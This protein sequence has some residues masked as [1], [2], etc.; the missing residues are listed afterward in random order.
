M[1]DLPNNFYNLDIYGKSSK[2]PYNS[3]GKMFGYHTLGFGSGVAAGLLPTQRAILGFGAVASGGAA[4][5]IT[6]LINSSGVIAADTSAVGTARIATAAANYGGD[7]AIFMGGYAGSS[8]YGLSNLVNASGVV[9]SDVTAVAD[10]VTQHFGV[11]FGTGLAGFFYGEVTGDTSYSNNKSLVSN[12]GV[13]SSTVNGAGTGRQSGPG[14]SYG[15]DKAIYYTGRI[16]A[17][18]FINESNLISN[19]G[20]QSADVT[21]VGLE[22]AFGAGA[23]YGEDKGIFAFGFSEAQNSNLNFSNTI[24]NVGVVSSDVDGVGTARRALSASG[25]GADKAIFMKGTSDQTNLV[26][27]QGVVQSDTNGVGTARYYSGAAGFS[28][29]A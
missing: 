26:N 9:G 6:N 3:R 22:K 28:N 1:K 11:K 19:T 20:V 14:T 2:R 21:G 27:N 13:V 15:G 17:N 7:K 5:G 12:L 29:T 10:N 23:S 18:T 8:G 24:T 25:Y 16:S 4:T